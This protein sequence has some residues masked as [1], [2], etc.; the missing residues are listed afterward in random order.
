[1]QQVK[2][3]ESREMDRFI[4]ECLPDGKYKQIQCYTFPM[5]SQT[6]CWCVDQQSGDEIKGTEVTNK[7]P[8]CPDG[9]VQFNYLEY[10]ITGLKY[11]YAE[12]NCL[13]HF[14]HKL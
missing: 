10:R 4:P 13:F 1:M 3:R 8:V 6:T 12:K 11:S 9:K 2:L 14:L 5:T 7:T